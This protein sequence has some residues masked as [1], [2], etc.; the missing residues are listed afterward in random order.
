MTT[1]NYSKL[2]IETHT[3]LDE[4]LKMYLQLVW[5]ARKCPA[6][7]EDYWGDVPEQ[8]RTGA[9]N[10]MAKVEEFF[11]DNVDALKDPMTGDW[12]HGF[13][14]GA[15]AVLRF[16]ETSMNSGIKEAKE[17]FPELDS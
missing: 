12:E 10:A 16:L 8:I 3:E 17:Q 14:S 7:C 4:M 5:Y 6:D 9:F 13:N 11:P 1:K 2:D 15:L